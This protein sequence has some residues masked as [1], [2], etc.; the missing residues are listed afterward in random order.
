MEVTETDPEM[1]LEVTHT[2]EINWHETISPAFDEQTIT[3]PQWLSDLFEVLRVR[4]TEEICDECQY[5]NGEGRSSWVCTDCG[6]P[7]AITYS[8]WPKVWE[9]ID[10]AR[11]G[12]HEAAQ[13]H[14][15]A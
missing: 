1:D 14:A 11:R 12:M 2:W 7:H 9:N 4:P 6:H 5:R 10:K 3:P 8:Y 15:D 13:E